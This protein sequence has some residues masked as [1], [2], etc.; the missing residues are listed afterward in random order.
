MKISGKIVDIFNKQIFNGELLIENGKIEKIIKTNDAENQYI[1]P[2]FI[3][4]HIHI[5][6]S[7][8]I[9]SRFAELSVPH[10][11]VACISDPHEIANVLGIDGVKFMIKNSKQCPQKFFFGAP[12]C[13]PA[14]DFE[15]SGARIDLDA[16]DELLQ[17]KDIHFLAEMMNFPGVINDLPEVIGKIELAKKYGK[18]IDGHAPLLSGKNLEKYAKAGI[19]TDH[20]CTNIKEAEEKIALGMKI[21]IR[22]GSAAKD[23]D[24]LFE[25]IDK[26]PENVMFCSD[27]RHPDDLV[28]GHINLLVKESIQRGAD[29]FNTLRAACIN[30]VEHYNIPV[31]LLRQGDY[32]DFIIIDNLNDFNIQKSFINGNLVFENGKINFKTNNLQ[33]KPNNFIEI[34]I[35]PEDLKIKAKSENIR[36]IKAFER[37]LLTK[38]MIA[39]AK[40]N[41]GFVESDIQNDILKIVVV[42][43]YQKTAPSIG[44]INGIGLKHGALATSVAHDSHN[45]IAVGCTDQEIAKAINTVAENKG[46][47]A[48]YN[49]GEISILPLPVAG[50]MSDRNG[51]EIA[52]K[53]KQLNEQA[54]AI[55]SKLDA[56]F[57][58]LSF[59]A[60]LVIP[61]LKIG[62]K[63]LFDVSKFQFSELF[64][65]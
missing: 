12:S 59:M 3:D 58:T 21:L 17:N 20:E 13:V 56:P 16:I 15:T 40:I 65:D 27:D 38:Q 52:E 41:N 47:M 51:K 18:P 46:G 37:S 8:L 43:R 63:G 10:G 31:G 62:D 48:I 25:L 2:G 61:E 24:N 22:N 1:L 36:V 5:E 9:P 34:K 39:K 14:T 11:T 50:L 4:S 55:G 29:L 28:Q 23:F 53:Y 45:I 57:M 44:F 33:I 64:A 42:N 32:A 30:P 35:N 49:N 26:Y 60:L 54:K 6:S 7:M 19:T